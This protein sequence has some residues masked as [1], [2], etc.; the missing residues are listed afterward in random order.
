MVPCIW[1][2]FLPIY[3]DMRLSRFGVP[4]AFKLIFITVLL[5]TATAVWITRQSSER[6]QE[7]S[8]DREEQS[9]R[10]QS[11]AR[12]TEIEG[13]IRSYIEK[14]KIVASLI[15][16]GHDSGT[17]DERSLELTFGGD[18]DLVS[19]E[20]RVRGKPFRESMRV[21]SEGYLRQ[22]GLDKRFINVLREIQTTTKRLQIDS[23]FA[24]G[25]NQVEIRNA[26]IVGGAPLLTI[27]FPMGTDETG[28]VTHAVVADVRLDRFQQVFSAISE[29]EMFMVDRDGQLLAHPDERRVLAESESM[30]DHPAVLAA[31]NS[32]VRQGQVRFTDS[33]SSTEYTAAYTK[34]SFGVS[35]VAMVSNEVILEA[36][37]AVER[38]A[39]FITGKALS[40]A[41]FAVFLFSISLTA[42]IERLVMLADSVA[43]GNFQG[44][45]TWRTRDE[46]GR[47]GTAFNTMI[48]GLIERDKVKQL[49]SKFHGSSVTA[50]LLKRD[51]QLGGAR[52]PV[53]VFFS[54]IRNFTQYS[55]GHSPEQ[56]VEM[57]NEY[58][59]IMVRIVNSHH[60][61]VDKFIGDAIMAVWGVPQSQISDTDDA[62]RA[63]LEMRK[64][65]AT[66]NEKR[67]K[68]GEPVIRIGMGLHKGQAI[69]G[70]IGSTE[71]M[72]YTV[73]GDTVNQASRIEAATKSLG[74]D[75][76]VSQ[77]VAESVRDK[78]IVEE[79][80]CVEVKGK[81]EPLKL[82][83][84]PGH[85]NA[86]KEP[87]IIKT[88]YSEYEA[89]ESEKVKV[90]G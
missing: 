87:V 83:K 24:G 47:L 26:S 8:I 32:P 76:L 12:A 84:V 42:P 48:Q 18:R 65:L 38:E 16:A 13:L 14:S 70:T 78:F 85:F 5:V 3:I 69:S 74:M 31:L 52:K 19:V 73:I 82:F 80:G 43:R 55:E 20:L 41:L 60:G 34:T 6:F 68:K 28:Q 17:K 11:F 33:K 72:E 86:K 63:C 53:T 77:E 50:D 57:L 61:V 88:A 49:F 30:R 67:I 51:V 39:Y 56:V 27:A 1:W 44:R 45:W 46:V 15:L 21:V 58:F 10:D 89:A 7:V 40:F 23:L 25:G 29:R 71:R 36:A 2:G 79:A 22:Y 37:K 75:L 90:A 59:Q 64:A 35:V 81:A 54:D 9:N 4:I 66:L 62:V